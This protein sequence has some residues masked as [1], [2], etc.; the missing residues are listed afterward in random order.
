MSAPASATIRIVFSAEHD[1]TVK[2][3]KGAAQALHYSSLGIFGLAS[4]ETTKVGASCLYG[5][6]I[7]TNEQFAKIFSVLADDPMKLST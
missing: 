7:L 6:L 4:S 2:S 1:G 5:E 3:L